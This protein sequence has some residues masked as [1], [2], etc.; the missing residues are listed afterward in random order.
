[1]DALSGMLDKET[2]EFNGVLNQ[3]SVSPLGG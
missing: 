3:S 1:M 2:K